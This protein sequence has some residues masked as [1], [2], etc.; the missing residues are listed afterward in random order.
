VQLGMEQELARERERDGE[1]G[2]RREAARGDSLDRQA[3]G[4]T[5]VADQAEAQAGDKR[6]G[7]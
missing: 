6:A 4:Q 1:R 7:E 5:P 2:L 3:P